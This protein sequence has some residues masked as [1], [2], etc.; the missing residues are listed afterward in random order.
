MPLGADQRQHI[1]LTLDLAT[2]F[3]GRFGDTFTL[4]K[5]YI[6]K[7]TA[8]I[9][10][11]QNPTVKMSTSAPT[12]KG[13]PNRLDEPKATAK[14]VRRAVTA[15]DTVIRYDVAEQPRVTT[16][17]RSTRPSPAPASPS[18]RRTTRARPTARSRRTWP[19]SWSTS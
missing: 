3:N 16:S 1:E 2:R 17:S 5:P 4:P 19:R 7:E 11:L 12:P 18:W 13:L 10:D 8:Q 9:D 15:T 6:L 14:K